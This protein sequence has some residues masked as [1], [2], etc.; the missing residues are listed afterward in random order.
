MDFNLTEEQLKLKEEVHQFVLE[1][2]APVI[3]EYDAK[4]E[5]PREIAEKA[6]EKGFMNVRIPKIF[7]IGTDFAAV[8]RK[9]C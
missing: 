9:E 4:D 8:W 3:G 5:F 1:E 2:V 7:P 6:F